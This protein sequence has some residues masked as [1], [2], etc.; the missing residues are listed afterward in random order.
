MGKSRVLQGYIDA[1][2]VWDLDQRRSTTGY[3]FIEAEC[4]ISWKIELQ[5][6]VA[7][8]TTKT[9]YMPA[10]KASNEAL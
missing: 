7:F 2:Y 3:V 4:V 9:E 1:D 10:V 5:D 6:T 8:S